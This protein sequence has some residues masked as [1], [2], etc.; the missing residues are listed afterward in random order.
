MNI[1]IISSLSVYHQLAQVFAKEDNV[2]NV[3]HYGSHSSVV[4][5]GKYQPYAMDVPIIGNVDDKLTEIFADLENKKIDF[6][7]ASGAA[8]PSSELAHSRLQELKIPY[9]F[10]K[11]KLTNLE[12]N[13]TQTKKM[14][15]SLNIPTGEGET[16]DGK[17]LFENFKSIPRPF[18]VKQNFAF[19]YGRQ[20][21]I[22]S[23]DNFEDVYLDLFSVRLDQPPRIT[24]INFDASI[25]IEKFIKIK[26]EYSYHILINSTGWKYLGSA[27][28]Y[29]KVNDGDIGFN[30]LSMGSYNISDV[31]PVVHG[32]A[33]KIV[34]FLIEK[35]FPYKGIMF[36]GIAVDE[37]DVPYILEIN[38]RSGDPEFLSILGSVE[39]NLSELFLAA[40]SDQSIP[41]ITHNNNKV[42]NIRMLNSIYDWTKPASFI[43]KLEPCPEDILFGLEGTDKFYIKHSVFTATGQTHEDAAQKIYSY[44][45]KQFVGQFRYRR[46]IGIL[47]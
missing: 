13:R 21:V 6:L 11:P 16:V 40:S 8:V 3:Y 19:Q 32:Y 39:N 27:R 47:K 7:L 37:N 12:K 18:V 44:L 14:L 33:D 41:D 28:D 9:F 26:R 29:K 5:S 23:D 35:G 2:N 24:N 38:A 34:K 1:A 30:C 22:V 46:D 36:L 42:V 15:N 45:D 20:T 43:P 31:D 17:Y 4:E 10:P 25:V